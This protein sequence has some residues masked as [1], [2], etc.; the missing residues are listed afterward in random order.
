[1]KHPLGNHQQQVVAHGNPNLCVDSVARCS[2]ERLDM[3][4]S[5]YEFEERLHVPT[6]AVKFCDGESRKTEVICNECVN[7]VCCIILVD[8]HAYPFRITLRRLES[9]EHN[10][11]ITNDTCTLVH[12]PF[13]DHLILHVVLCP[14]DKE[15]ML[16]VE[17]I[18]EPLEVYIAFIH[19]VVSKSLYRQ[20][21]HYLAV[22]N[23]AFRKVNEGGYT[24]SEAKQGMHFEGSLLM[25]EFCPRTKLEAKL[26]CTAVESIDHIFYVQT[27][28]VFV[29][30]FSCLLDKVLDQV[31]VN[32]PVLGLIQIGKCGAWDKRKTGMVQLTL[33]S[34]K[35]CLIGAETLLGSELCEAHHHELVT[36]GELDLMSVATVP[37][38]T[39][40]ED[41]LWEQRHDLGEYT[42]TLIHLICS[43]HYYQMQRYKIK[44]SKNIVAVNH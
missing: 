14:R 15:S 18:I 24:T 11:L 26:D 27:I 30:K 5:L 39:L 6:F 12:R 2:I 33:E 1:M 21:I 7:I 32:V 13:C 10:I 36:A 28:V 17:K 44:S 23:L 20:L 9:C 22:V 19:Q 38:D 25:M 37:C 3:Q 31:V 29:I 35:G 42:L 34:C 40:A 16:L 4:T 43:L 41:V 8:H